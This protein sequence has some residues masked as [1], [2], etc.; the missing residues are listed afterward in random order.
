M[1]DESDY[2]EPIP[3]PKKESPTQATTLTQP[4]FEI[5]QFSEKV[6]DTRLFFQIIFMKDSYFVWIGTA[7]PQLANLAFAISTPFVNY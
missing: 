5:Q 1:D 4:T 7:A 2:D 3:L 6:H